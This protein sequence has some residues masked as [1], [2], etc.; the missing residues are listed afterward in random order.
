MNL[1]KHTGIVN[2]LGAY[3]E[4]T[5]TVP[6]ISFWRTPEEALV[7]HSLEK[8]FIRIGTQNLERWLRKVV[9]ADLPVGLKFFARV[10]NNDTEVYAVEDTT[11]ETFLEWYDFTWLCSQSNINLAVVPREDCPKEST[12]GTRRYVYQNSE[13]VSMSTPDRT[14]DMVRTSKEE[15]H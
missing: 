14:N 1:K 12:S 9:D 4:M 13:H 2:V 8:G 11:N 7:V 10:L 15:L 3:P 5:S 6:Q